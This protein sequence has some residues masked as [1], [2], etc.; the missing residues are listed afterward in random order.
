M[1]G[2]FVGYFE[3]CVLGVSYVVF[4]WYLCIGVVSSCVKLTV[5]KCF[6]C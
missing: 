1:G 6:V 4:G 2:L 5:G 3:G